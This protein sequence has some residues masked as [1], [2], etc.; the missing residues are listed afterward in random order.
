MYDFISYSTEPPPTIRLLTPKSV[1]SNKSKGCAFLE[2][3]HHNSLQQALKLHQSTLE[4]RKINIELTVGGGGKG[5]GRIAKLQGRNRGLQDQRV[6]QVLSLLRLVRITRRCSSRRKNGRK[7]VL[8][9]TILTRRTLQ[10]DPN[11]T[12][13]RL[14]LA[15]FLQRSELGRWKIT[16]K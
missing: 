13:R 8:P 10:N 9:P 14:G 16:T 15:K 6:R 1:P 12:Q 5:Q 7:K 2:F 11:G 4:G 3:S